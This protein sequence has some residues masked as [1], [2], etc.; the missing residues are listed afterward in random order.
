MSLRPLF[1][2][3]DSIAD[4]LAEGTAILTPNRRLSRAVRE[5][6]TQYRLANGVQVWTSSTIL[7][8][9][10]YWIERWRIAVTRG[11]IPPA[12][13]VDTTAQRLIWRRVIDADSQ[14]SFSLLSPAR[15]ATLCQEASER[16]ALWRINLDDPATRQSFSF[17]EDSR[18][19]LRWE[20]NF[21]K[22]L[23][24]LDGITPEQA[25]EQL[26][27]CSAALDQAV[28][29]LNQDDLPPL[30]Q[31]LC[32]ASPAW[33][34]IQTASS[35]GSILPVR[36]FSDPRGE[37]QMAAKW[38][39]EKY[40]SD[41]EGRYAV[42]LSDMHNDRDRLEF[43]LRQEF[44]CLTQ[45]YSSLPV[46]FATG[47]RLDRVPL[48]RD[49][50]RILELSVSEVSIETVIAVVQSRFVKPFAFRADQRERSI[51][52]LR[53]LAKDKVPQ[54]VLRSV[55]DELFD[56]DEAPA[57]WDTVLQLE[58]NGAW[59]KRP[60]SPSQWLEP[61]KAVLNAWGWTLG[62]TLDSLEYQ[63]A[64]QWQEALD[65]FASLDAFSGALT[66]PEA[67]Q[68]LRD[69]LSEQQ[70]Q[71]RTD[72]NAVQVLGPLETTGLHFDALWITGM[73]ADR[74]PA[75]AHA[76]PYLPHALQ[77][78]QGM[79][80][81]DAAWER[82]WASARWEQWLQGSNELQT[83]YVSLLDGTEALPSPLLLDIPQ[84]PEIEEWSADSRWLK[85]SSS[86]VF[87]EVSWD[88]VPVGK[89]ERAAQGVGT[90]VLEQQSA[91]PFQ[92]FAT[93]RLGA[94]PLPTPAVGLLASE[95]GTLLH[96]ALFELWGE[97]QNREGLL[98]L[99]AEQLDAL[100]DKAV[101]YA[102]QGIQ[103]ERLDVLGGETLWLERRRLS[104]VLSRW[105][106]LEQDRSEDFAVIAR[107][108]S[109]EHELAGLRLRMRLDRVD[110]LSDGSRLIIDYKSGALGTVNQWLGERPSRPQ[111]PLY[112]LLEPLAEGISY[113]SLK[114]GAE[115][116][117]GIGE[118]EFE[119]GIANAEKFL[120][121]GEQGGIGVLRERWKHALT[122]LAEEFLEGHSVV[123]PTDE[124]C[125]YCQRFELCR[126]GEQQ[127]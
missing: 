30:H 83:S 122:L 73:S 24:E 16:L 42:V 113:A 57:P 62:A 123:N 93:A 33:K 39:R 22:A 125:R 56:K 68:G 114:P 79:P 11:L 94:V 44:G 84:A 99:T 112:A 102:E 95:R 111:L 49:A 97:F 90:G 126:L 87:A 127:S 47:F 82:R 52:R 92:A 86:A 76:N 48:I 25:L 78:Q 109:R 74:W 64:V 108:E 55:L 40:E 2:H 96:R 106:A 36:A 51:R 117:K 107:E 41:P 118:R 69:V 54:R 89:K 19:F 23:N 81:A 29:L 65:T 77:R 53:E 8:L 61:F 15:A 72:D 121:E 1:T 71:P 91:C 66:L 101:N 6:E 12:N 21:R 43:Y 14:G 60:R 10:Q 34:N 70:F 100:I 3:I 17:D 85:Q 46:N 119:D 4:L 116:F 98:A 120:E 20:E 5:A 103:K 80:H 28:A 9:R 75:V 35:A 26:L 50:L 58:A 37:L 115:G 88:E 110:E 13:V 105:L 104:S 59:Q 38:C 45:N 31:A 32:E 18:A 7:P 27:N 124:A 63:Q 67:I